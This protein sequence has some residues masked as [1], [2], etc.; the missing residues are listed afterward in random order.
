MSMTG[1]MRSM[2]ALCGVL[3]VGVLLMGGSSSTAWAQGES[4][5][6][7]GLP[8]AVFTKEAGKVAEVPMPRV[9]GPLPSI[10]GPSRNYTWLTTDEN[11]KRCGYVEREFYIEGTARAYKIPTNLTDY[12]LLGSGYAYKTRVVV[13]YPVNQRRFSGNVLLE[14]NNVTT[15][16]D[17]DFNWLETCDYIMR[18]GHAYVSVS[19]QKVGVDALKAWSPARYGSLDV[20]GGGLFPQD[21]LSFDIYS[22]VAQAIRDNKSTKLLGGLIKGHPE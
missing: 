5:V 13:R 3:L 11:L 1:K 21:Q 8:N 22:Q 6:A 17:I 20:S 9:I 2:P 15:G 7:S 16:V 10:I 14:W 18:S 4:N 12:Q 19:A